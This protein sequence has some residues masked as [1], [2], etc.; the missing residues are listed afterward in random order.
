MSTAILAVASGA[1]IGLGATLV[2]AVRWARPTLADRLTEPDPVSTPTAPGPDEHPGWATRLGRVGV[3]ALAAL[4]MPNAHTRQRLRECERTTES[5]LAEKSTALL[6]G[7]F[8]PALL[9]VAALIAGVNPAPP[10]A[11]MWALLILVC[12][13]APDLALK[14]HAEQ[15]RQ[16][17]RHTVAAFAELTTLALAGGA[18]VSAALNDATS[19]GDGWAMQRLRTALRQAAVRSEPPWDVLGELGRRY[20]VSELDEVATSLQLAG[21]DGARVR[22]SLKAKA[23]TFRTQHHAEVEARADSATERMALPVVGLVAAFLILIAYPAL[24]IVTTTL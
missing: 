9:T 2:L 8:A 17:M 23:A 1:L 3:P 13:F 14:Q 21:A 22:S 12:W 11:G 19:T 18:G 4:G 5:Y 24:S 15:R 16:E 20:G 7:A 6:T 10:W